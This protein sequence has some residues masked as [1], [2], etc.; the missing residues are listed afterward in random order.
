MLIT[1]FLVA[2]VAA[3]AGVALITLTVMGIAREEADW[4]LHADP[5]PAHRR[6]P[7]ASSACT[8]RSGGSRRDEADAGLAR[9]ASPASAAI[10]S[11]H[12]VLNDAIGVPVIT[13]ANLSSVPTTDEVEAPGLP[14]PPAL[15]RAR[16]CGRRG[17]RRTALR[18]S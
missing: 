8:P 13:A 15:C 9:R 17:S 12:R 18:H 6:S 7:G 3:V 16:S 4:S 1:V 11:Q 2:A 14:L 5:R 10:P